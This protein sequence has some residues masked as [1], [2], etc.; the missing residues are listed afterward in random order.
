ME[1][2]FSTIERAGIQLQNIISDT[3][4]PLGNLLKEELESKIKES[5]NKLPPVCRQVFIMS[6]FQ[7]MTYEEISQKLGISINTVK[8]H[9]KSALVVLKKNWELFYVLFLLFILPSYNKNCSI[10]KGT[11]FM[12]EQSLHTDTV[13]DWIIGYLT[14]SLTQEEMQLLQ[15][16]LNISEENRKYFPIC[17]KSG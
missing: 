14:N 4:Q 16:W 6:R 2:H 11:I 1:V 3:Q 15:D 9:I 8:Y 5:V 10:Y 12:N 13:N 7:E 17:K